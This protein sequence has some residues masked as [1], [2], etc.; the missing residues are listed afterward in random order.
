MIKL[1]IFIFFIIFNNNLFAEN[2]N[3]S[4]ASTTSTHDTGLLEYINKYFTEEFN[5]NVKVLS[6]GTGQAIRV[7]KDG[8][9]EI[10]L[11]HHLP[12]E[13]EFMN[14][15]HGILRHNLMYNDFVLVGP[16]EDEKECLSIGSKL[17]EIAKNKLIFIS[18]GDDSGTH[19]KEK[20][21]WDLIKM[22]PNSNSSWYLSIGQSMG[23][24]L[25][26]ANN[27]K[28]YS[29]SDRSTWISFNKKDN[30]KIVCQNLP[31]LF[32]QYGIILVNNSLNEKLNIKDA[33]KFITWII[34]D[35]GKMLINNYKI[36]GEQLFFFNYN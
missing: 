9:A 19:K 28:A 34:S 6:L 35:K 13:L 11:V 30:L 29:L 36:N 20:E 15:R 17:K 1:L 31:P 22:K 23:Q 24:T 14:N 18:R 32:N 7:A 25:L 33:K 4:I 16:R 26:M 12:S 3:I 21:L 27:K 10:L 5:I 2:R 8:N